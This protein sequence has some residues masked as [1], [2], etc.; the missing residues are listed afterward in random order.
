MRDISAASIF[1]KT[2]MAVA[3]TVAIGSVLGAAQIRPAAADSRR[4]AA[5]A[6]AAGFAAG[7]AVGATATSPRY[8]R[9]APRAVVKSRC[10]VKTTKKWNP[11]S[12]TYVVVKRR[13]C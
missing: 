10:T 8:V 12:R 9:P 13:S 6:G 3:A 11:R 7:V 5:A 2:S 4:D 1:G